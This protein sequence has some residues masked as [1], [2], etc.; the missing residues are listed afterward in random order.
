MGSYDGT[1]VCELVGLYLL[2]LLTNEFGKNNNRF[3]R[4]DGL[5]SFQNI[6]GPDSEKMKNKMCKIF[7]E[8]GL[9]ITVSYSLHITNFLDVT[10]DLKSG[11]Y[12]PYRKQNNEILYIHKQ[13]NHPPSLIKQMP[14]MIS[15]RM[16][17][18][19]CEC[20]HFYKAAPDYNTALKK[21]VSMR[22]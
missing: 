19:S 20:D 18:I 17:D 3:I 16:T 1:E 15:K 8:N 5:S 6:S 9:N 12:Y 21:V 11:T 14:L 13:S 2:N 22:I 4:D 10:F 7:K